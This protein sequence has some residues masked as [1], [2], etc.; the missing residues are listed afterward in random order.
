MSENVLM[1]RALEVFARGYC[2][3]RSFHASLPGRSGGPDLGG[4]GRAQKTRH[5]PPRGVDRA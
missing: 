4:P 5:V 3:T 2:F 1:Q